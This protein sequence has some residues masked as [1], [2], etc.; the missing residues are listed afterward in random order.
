MK[1]NDI[2]RVG[3]TKTL[4]TDSYVL[5]AV[6]S[7]KEKCG[8]S[9]VEKHI[10]ALISL[11]KLEDGK[12]NPKVR[13][14]GSKLVT[15]AGTTY[16]YVVAQ[17]FWLSRRIFETYCQLSRRSRDK[18]TKLAPENSILRFITAFYKMKLNELFSRTNAVYPLLIDFKIQLC[19]T[20]FTRY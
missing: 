19:P 4:I 7:P 8:G 10:N 15:K 18:M 17:G 12:K 14:L 13:A 1:P 3:N 5:F 20:H 6:V 16:D 11:I 9:T 2:E